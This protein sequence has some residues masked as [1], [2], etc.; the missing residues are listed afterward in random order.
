MAKRTL[1]LGPLTQ[2][3]M[4]SIRQRYLDGATCK[5]LATE[6]GVTISWLYSRLSD[7]R[8][9]RP[10]DAKPIVVEKS[11][12]VPIVNPNWSLKDM[13]V[14]CP[15]YILYL[16]ASGMLDDEQLKE[17]GVR[18]RN[19][20]LE[21]SIVS[22]DRCLSEIVRDYPSLLLRTMV[23]LEVYEP[24]KRPHGAF[25]KGPRVE[26][27]VHPFL[28]TANHDPDKFDPDSKLMKD[29]AQLSLGFALG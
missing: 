23:R 10:K 17:I 20:E 1:E 25:R 5:S 29:I 21:L 28:D 19:L 8:K 6:Y 22:E 4:T 15:H 14:R 26:D 9:Y 2:Q 13:M 24:Q 16:F 3:E 7:L 12:P 18:R 27:E 11:K